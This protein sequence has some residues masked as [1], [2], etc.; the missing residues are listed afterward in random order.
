MEL[1]KLNSILNGCESLFKWP[2]VA[3][4]GRKSWLNDALGRD[5]DK[6]RRSMAALDDT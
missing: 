4:T 6:D 5:P 2:K 1:F 3:R